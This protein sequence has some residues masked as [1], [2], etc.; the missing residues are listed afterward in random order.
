MQQFQP[1]SH[2]RG[3]GGATMLSC[4]QQGIQNLPQSRLNSHSFK[5]RLI[6]SFLA[7]SVISA[8]YSPLQ[9]AWVHN[10]PDGNSE[11]GNDLTISSGG[12]VN[13]KNWIFYTN[14]GSAGTLTINA[15][16]STSGGGAGGGVSV[17][18][19]TNVGGIILSSGK[20]LTTQQHGIFNQ[21]TIT[22]LEV[23]GTINNTGGN[24]I[25]NESGGRIENL[26]IKQGANLKTIN[27]A[28][29]SQGIGTLTIENG[30]TVSG[31]FQT[32]H[33]ID[34]LKVSGNIQKNLSNYGYIKNIEWD[35]TA[36]ITD[37]AIFIR[38]ILAG[39]FTNKGTITHLIVENYLAADYDEGRIEGKII[40]DGGTIEKI[41]NNTEIRRGIEIKSGTISSG[42][43]NT[44]TI[45]GQ[46][47][48]IENGGSIGDKIEN[49][50]GTI[51]QIKNNSSLSNIDN[52]G[53]IN[54][55]NGTGTI[56]T[57]T[58]NGK[59]TNSGG[60]ISTLNNMNTITNQSGTITT[61]NN[62]GSGNVMNT[63][64]TITTLNNNN[65]NA[66]VTNQ[67]GTIATLTNTSGRVMNTGGT[68]T[69]LN[70]TGGNVN[71][72]SGT[73]STLNNSA[74]VMNTSGGSITTLNNTSANA[75]VNNLGTITTLN[76]TGG[77]VNNSANIQTLQSTNGNINNM[78]GTIS[79]LTNNNGG[80][81]NN[82]QGTIENLKITSGD[83]ELNNMQQGRIAN[84]E[85]GGNG[86]ININDNMN[87]GYSNGIST[88][89]IASGAAPT[90]NF[91]EV[92]TATTAQETYATVKLVDSTNNANTTQAKVAID[93]LT[94]AL[95]GEDTQIGKSVSLANSV[96][97]A[98]NS[99][100][101]NVYVKSADFSQDLKQ[102]G[103]Y[104][105]FNAQTQTI[106]TRFNANLGAAGLFSQVFINQLGRRS[107]LF[108]S[109]LNEASR[110][111]LRYK[112]TQPDTNFDIFVRP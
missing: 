44:G 10:K 75:K 15:D 104:G 24:S 42:I 68:I 107:L 63:G 77:N 16:L 35:T 39:D 28:G 46:G 87:I 23:G 43:V 71:N 90:L 108:D 101:G 47:I 27:N 48:V 69:M 88:F 72:Q 38:S 2:T 66:S 58:N 20:T 3:G 14:Q 78:K 5:S 106:D 7:L 86:N 65:A 85:I 8:L 36:N 34:K 80:S 30:A 103:F 49:R 102:S 84:I 41:I 111:S 56:T 45:G 22:N 82:Y 4:N 89:R 55:I 6:P 13:N 93:K 99:G 53:T 32:Y 37:G 40:N 110:A 109:F 11:N 61:L 31:G 67:S 54:A 21:G 50:G 105:T 51:S 60:T 94:I 76:N 9:A 57:L 29:N 19:N 83:F 92:R 81:L 100:V 26:T 91:G 74:N 112:R 73:I 97:G 79:T 33:R 17:N 62:N 96:S 70:N 25:R 64:G 95:V 59:A 18:R 1:N 12:T 52:S 98:A